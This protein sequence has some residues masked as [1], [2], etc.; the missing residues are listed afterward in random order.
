MLANAEVAFTVMVLVL[1]YG[2]PVI[3]LLAAWLIGRG[4]ERRHIA[5]LQRRE[6]DVGKRIIV[7]SEKRLP[8]GV[9]LVRG[10]MVSLRLMLALEIFRRLAA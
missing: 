10:Q 7:T 6:A 4:I 2:S 5:S 9:A 8:G 3:V 1:S